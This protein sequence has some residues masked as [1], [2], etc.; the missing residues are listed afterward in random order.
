VNRIKQVLS[1]F[2]KKALL[3]SNFSGEKDVVNSAWYFMLEAIDVES[4]T[5]S[6]EIPASVKQ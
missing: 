4:G 6:F 5:N 2:A 3:V 1:A